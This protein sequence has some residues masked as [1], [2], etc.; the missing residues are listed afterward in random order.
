[1]DSLTA[2]LTQAID[3]GIPVFVL[4]AEIEIEG[5]YSVTID[6]EKLVTGSLE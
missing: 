6:H 5:V 2:S 4:D 1:M 3:K